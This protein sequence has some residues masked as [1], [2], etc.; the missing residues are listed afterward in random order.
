MK[1]QITHLEVRRS[2]RDLSSVELPVVSDR[3][4]PSFSLVKLPTVCRTVSGTVSGTGKSRS[5]AFT[6]VE[7]LVV[8]A[9]IGILVSLLLPA[10]Q[11]AREA[12]RRMSC[13]N[14]IRQ[15]TL[16]VLNYESSRTEL[17]PMGLN[18]QAGTRT[19]LDRGPQFSWIVLLLPY[20]EQG[21]LHDQ[22]DFNEDAFNQVNEPQEQFV[23]VLQ[24]P[25]DESRGRFFQHNI[26]S[27]RKRFAKGNY[28]AYVSPVHTDQS[29]P[30]PG[31][32]I[33]EGQPMSRVIDGASNTIVLAEIRS[34]DNE[35]DP[36]GAWTLSWTATTLLAFDMHHFD[37]PQGAGDIGRPSGYLASPKS[38]GLGQPP[39]NNG[40]VQSDMIVNCPD[41]AGAQLIGMKCAKESWKSAAPRSL[42][43]GGVYISRLD[44]SVGFLEDDIDEFAMVY[45]VAINDSQITQ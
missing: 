7:L 35:R 9:I 1:Q 29:Q 21:N 33:I 6:L 13:Q 20:F 44:G 42:H 12:A 28:A 30:Y 34:R 17:P 31:A 22:F 8:I 26:W 23:D 25:S 3:K 24:C 36:R 32:L 15:L 38:V 11:A 39:N 27:K 19:L 10:V 40:I 2:D 5:A 37:D 14:N 43:V 18:R 41:P 45:M 16:A 4:S